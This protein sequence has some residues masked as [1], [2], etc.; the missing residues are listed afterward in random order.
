M[1][2][3]FLHISKNGGMTLRKIID[4]QYRKYQ[5][6][7][8][9]KPGCNEALSEFNKKSYFYRKRIKIIKGKHF[10]YGCHR[11][12]PNPGG[13]KYFAMLRN[14]IER[15]FSF[16][17]YVKRHPNHDL[18]DE[19]HKTDL[20]FTEFIKNDKLNMEIRN[21]QT[22]FIAGVGQNGKCTLQI[23]DRALDNIKKTFFLVGILENYKETLFLLK[24]KL[25]WKSPIHYELIN[26]N[27]IKKYSP[28]AEEIE[29]LT[30]LNKYDLQLYDKYK[31]L[32]DVELEKYSK[33][34]LELFINN[35]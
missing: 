29:I 3:I 10:A 24:Q 4:G 18:Y 28:S 20:S 7:N 14:P 12:L 34:N 1:K 17:S 35:L 6:Y 30:R 31:L 25:K 32:F 26:T 2:Y 9:T 27:P 19:I 22:K 11:T 5:I 21:G 13:A 15:A 33:L 23:F 8:I 16:Y